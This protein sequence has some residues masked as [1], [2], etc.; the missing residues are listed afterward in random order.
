MELTAHN[1]ACQRGGRTVFAGTGF[2]LASG[3]LLKIVGPNGSGKSSLLRLIAGLNEPAEG[4]LTLSGGDAELEIGQ[5][6]HLIA[7]QDAL[8]PALTVSENLAFWA[9]MLGGGDRAAA[10]AAFALERLHETPAS[11]LSA[12][13]R[14]RLS[15]ARLALAARPIWLLDEPHSSLDADSQTRLNGLI[16]DH[17]G[18]GGLAIVATHVPLAFAQ[19]SALDLSAAR[20]VA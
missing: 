8:K 19:A 16:A 20:H 3:G 2:T 14:R 7:H 12:G 5:Q 17:L 18:K 4:T 6:C 13:Q 9:N 15:L 11:L 1:L 10:L